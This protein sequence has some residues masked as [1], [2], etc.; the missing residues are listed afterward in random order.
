MSGVYSYI[1]E[2]RVTYVG[3]MI[4]LFFSWFAAV[5][6]SQTYNFDILVTV[7]LNSTTDDGIPTA[8][9]LRQSWQEGE[10]ML[11]SAQLALQNLNQQCFPLQM[12]VT[13]LQT[14]CSLARV[15]LVEMVR[16][17]V[18][19]GK[20][21]IAVVG[22]FCRPILHELLGITEH[23]RLGVV[24][25]GLNPFPPETEKEE[26]NYSHEVSVSSLEY[27]EALSQFVQRVSWAQIAV[28]TISESSTSF[29][30]KVA[31]QMVQ[32]LT[33]RWIKVVKV[34]WEESTE[35]TVRAIHGTGLTQVYVLL[36]PEETISLLCNAYDYGLRWPDYGWLVPDIS[37]EDVRSAVIHSKHC[38]PQA[39]NGIVSFQI[40][41]TSTESGYIPENNTYSYKLDTQEENIFAMAMY[42]WIHSVYFALNDAFPQ[43]SQYFREGGRTDTKLTAQKKISEFVG[44][45]LKNGS[46]SRKFGD[47]IFFSTITA[48]Q[49]VKSSQTQLAVYNSLVNTTLFQNF[50]AVSLPTGT[51]KHVYRILPGHV[52]AILTT[53]LVVCVLFIFFNM[54]LYIYYRKA[55]EMKASSVGI[56][57]MIYVSCYVICVGCGIDLKTSTYIVT[58]RSLCSAIIWTIYPPSDLILA[59]LLVQIGRIYHIF[60]HFRRIKKLARD[61]NLVLVICFIVLGKIL[62]LSLWTGLDPFVIVDV[63]LYHP[64]AKPPYYEI[65]QTCRSNH[66]FLWASLT[67]VYSAILIGFVAFLSYKTRK[68]RRKDFKNT[69]KINIL[70]SV[71][72]ISMA[73]LLP[74]WWIFRSLGNTVVSRVIIASFY[75]I[76][77]MSCQACL[78]C[79]KTLPPLM[80][81]VSRCLWKKKHVNQERKKSMDRVVFLQKPDP[82]QLSLFL[83]RQSTQASLDS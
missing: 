56:S 62:L 61:R 38:D 43:I 75:L 78:F 5:S 24:T 83:S 55:P 51:L 28:V 11:K 45:A 76:I 18:A 68:I 14:D 25:I 1:S 40:T 8:P 82:S 22:V 33:R 57:L 30:L 49:I 54:C 17:L 48:Y 4:L 13:Q 81:S 73:I 10:A 71:A 72:V 39:G 58:H 7:P 70:L 21:T 31:E 29:Y 6:L 80:R 20:I 12:S 65:V 79:P 34:I 67:I 59:T 41:K 42:D 16:E 23:D 60:S 35:Q 46:T 44:K 66:F 69:K 27:V 15:P 52:D 19:P 37:L 63:E 77:P 32:I 26:Q 9:A 3:K 53:G 50:S 47:G 74:L 2:R 36:P 64:Q